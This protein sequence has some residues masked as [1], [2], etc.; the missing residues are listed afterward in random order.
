MN[1]ARGLQ[2][3]DLAAPGKWIWTTS[4]P[5]WNYDLQEYVLYGGLTGDS[6]AVPQV[7]GAAALLLSAAPSLDA[8]R[9]KQVLMDSTDK[10]PSL[11]GKC[12]SG[13]RLNVHKALLELKLRLTRHPVDDDS[14]GGTVGN[15]DGIINP[16]ETIGLGIDLHNETRITYANLTG[17]LALTSGS[18]SYVTITQSTQNYGN[19]APGNSPS[20]SYILQV[21]PGTPT[22]YPITLTHTL[23]S[24][25]QD[26]IVEQWD[27]VVA[28]SSIVSGTVTTGGSPLAGATVSYSGTTGGDNQPT[29]G[30]R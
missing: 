11:E 13:G 6:A 12:V 2:S 15:D 28:S 27:F 29:S 21:A 10:L 3:V 17:T 19:V 24:D 25:G 18:A 9:I 14:V 4:I 22:P 26:P 7:A 23:S 1:R 30:S 20:G 8:A 16:G 5:T